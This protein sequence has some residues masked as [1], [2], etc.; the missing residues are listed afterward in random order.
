MSTV[1]VLELQQLLNDPRSIDKLM[2]QVRMILSAIHQYRQDMMAGDEE[3]EFR[4]PVSDEDFDAA[5]R[6]YEILCGAVNERLTVCLSQITAGNPREAVRLAEVSP[7]LL[8]LFAAIDLSDAERQDWGETLIE[9]EFA[10]PAFIHRDKAET[11]AEAYGQLSPDLD[12]L[13]A[14]LR[15]LALARAPLSDRLSV[16]RQMAQLDVR[17]TADLKDWQKVRLEQLD[18]E[19]DEAY[20]LRLTDPQSAFSQLVAR[21]NELAADNWPDS[22]AERQDL[23]RKVDRRMR[24]VQEI[25][26]SAPP[27]VP[28]KPPLAD[29]VARKPASKQTESAKRATTTAP[30][31][32]AAMAEP[33]LEPIAE[34][35]VEPIPPF[36]FPL[37]QASSL[38]VES[39]TE[40]AVREVASSSSSSSSTEHRGNSTR[41]LI[42]VALFALAAVIIVGVSGY[43]Y[44]VPRWQ[45][46]RLR[47]V[48]EQQWKEKLSEVQKAVEQHQAEIVAFSRLPLQPASPIP[49]GQRVRETFKT[50]QSSEQAARQLVAEKRWERYLPEWESSLAKLSAPLVEPQKQLGENVVA[51]LKTI[52]SSLT[53]QR[54]S[55]GKGA[56]D[57]VNIVLRN[58]HQQLSDIEPL[59]EV[60]PVV[61]SR[62]D[63]LLKLHDELL[64]ESAHE[65]DKNRRTIDLDKASAAIR[66]VEAL[67]KYVEQV[68]DYVSVYPNDARGR[69]FE[70]VLSEL[71]LWQSVFGQGKYL[72]VGWLDQKGETWRCRS[73]WSNTQK[74]DMKIVLGGD[75]NS[76]KWITVG[77][78][79]NGVSELTTQSNSY[80]RRGRLVFVDLPQN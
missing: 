41:K 40:E 21:L 44:M 46:Q 8:D 79:K 35:A 53:T 13:S 47:L 55:I 34:P 20:R 2:R 37:P 16:L 36:E 22:P 19:A 9:N 54:E 11:L 77:S 43:F 42:V 25:L 57:E 64:L 67:N 69:E 27:P 60:L 62:T 6:Q 73:R 5:V 70:D 76:P 74:L 59:C 3:A 39:R 66:N 30:P 80:F 29:K 51:F 10:A 72:A 33:I 17:F 45:E 78:I 24:S 38:W 18:R 7:R 28:E 61:R 4:R 71:P 65:R 15:I 1:S 14:E 58:K 56:L 31:P 52:D 26:R 32:Q 75:A 50:Y 48:A 63:Q 49:S 68:R 23:E 12:R